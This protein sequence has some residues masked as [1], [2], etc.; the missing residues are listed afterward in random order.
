M[1]RDLPE[2]VRCGSLRARCFRYVPRDFRGMENGVREA[3]EGTRRGPRVV[4]ENLPRPEPREASAGTVC[5]W[6]RP[7][8]ATHQCAIITAATISRR[9]RRAHCDGPGDTLPSRRLN[10][11][12]SAGW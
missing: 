10:R 3:E 8:E 12:L 5:R 1:R 11:R 9:N 7:S 4:F 2:Y 6:P